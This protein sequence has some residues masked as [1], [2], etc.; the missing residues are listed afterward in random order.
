M[1]CHFSLFS[2]DMAQRD[3][4]VSGLLLQAVQLL[5]STST[6]TV[7][8]VDERR[9]ASTS[10]A[11]EHRSLFSSWRRDGRSASSS[12]SRGECQCSKISINIYLHETN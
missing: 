3:P 12:S 10:I 11:A 2:K 1:L 4:D 7:S 9:S 6:S 8:S 5:R